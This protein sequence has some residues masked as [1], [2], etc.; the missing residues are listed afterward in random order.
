M[1]SGIVLAVVMAV[2]GATVAEVIINEKC[3]G[4]RES[5]T[6]SEVTEVTVTPCDDATGEP[7]SPCRLQRG[8]NSTAE[9]SVTFTPR[10]KHKKMKA[11]IVWASGAVELPMRGMQ[12]NGCR[13]LTTGRCPT[14][15]SLTHVW[16]ASI[17]LLPSFP[18]NDYPLKLKIM[19]GTKYIVCQQISIKLL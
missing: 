18:A 7:T 2:I 9:I 1:R 13:S 5:N 3:S 15:P 6:L 12:S 10:Q 14:T 11:S 8:A 19:D 16:K 17:P 4:R